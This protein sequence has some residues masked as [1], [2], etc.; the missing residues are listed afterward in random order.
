M[1]FKNK[2]KRYCT[3]LSF[4]LLVCQ[5]SLAQNTT[6]TKDSLRTPEKT[7]LNALDSIYNQGTQQYTQCDPNF[8][9]QFSKPKFWD[10]FRYIPND[11]YRFGKFTVQKENLKWDALV[12]GSTAAIIPYD[13]KLLEDAG[14]IGHKLG[15]WDKDSKYGKVFG[16]LTIVPKN[17]PSAVYY[18]GNGGTTL[19]LSGMFY[20]IGKLHHN[21]ARALNT[22]N[23]LVECLF[24]VGVTTQT[25]KRMTGRQSPSRALLTGND[26]GEWNPFPSFSAYQSRT[27]N[28]DAMPS[29]H[30]ATFMATVT[31][32]A[33]NYPEHKWIKPVGYSTMGL[34]AFNMVSGKVHWTSDYPI[35]IFIGYVMG[36]E[37]AN[38]RIT[39]IAKNKVGLMAPVKNHY[40]LN[41][42]MNNYF[43]TTLVGATITF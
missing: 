10:M 4:L 13:Q 41:Y 31:I 8:I 7:K 22:S 30:I 23:E 3:T 5:A 43:N 29:G 18:I 11:L 26:G 20:G 36:K 12:L 14:E 32:I 39:K 42:S 24:S 28:Y 16:V 6:Q 25:I 17:I 27:P 1:N 34:L 35:G 38:R 40:K 15:G 21:D 19:L 37:I 33:T 9:Y 2:L